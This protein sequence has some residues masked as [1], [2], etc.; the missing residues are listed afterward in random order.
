KRAAYDAERIVDEVVGDWERR[1]NAQAVTPTIKALRA[2]MRRGLEAELGRSLRGKLRGLDA[3]QRAAVAR[4]LDAGINRILHDPVTH[5]R[6][7]AVR[8]D[9]LEVADVTTMLS[10]LFE[11]ADVPATD[12]D[13]SG[14]RLPDRDGGEVTYLPEEPAN[15]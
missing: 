9:G 1:Q 5:L 8:S 14:V 4:M 6:D 12:L 2:K 13:V 10:D 7:E 3:E 11:L 15:A